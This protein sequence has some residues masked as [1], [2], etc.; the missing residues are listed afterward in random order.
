MRQAPKQMAVVYQALA[1]SACLIEVHLRKNAATRPC[2]KY[3]NALPAARDL[4]LS[5][6]CI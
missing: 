3:P 2:N 5:A 1:P 4:L 6:E